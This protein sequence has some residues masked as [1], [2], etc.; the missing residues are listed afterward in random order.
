MKRCSLAFFIQPNIRIESVPLSLSLSFLD[1]RTRSCSSR[2]CRERVSLSACSSE[3]AEK[4]ETG[5]AQRRTRKANLSASEQ[6][7]VFVG[8][9]KEEKKEKPKTMTPLQQQQQAAADALSA[10]TKKREDCISGAILAGS[11]S[12]A[13]ALA[14]SGAAVAAATLFL[15]PFAAATNVSARTALI[16]TPAFG[17]FFL[18]SELALS[19]CARRRRR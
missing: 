9:Q 1:A 12:A 16:V 4:R 14:L 2:L 8:E 17:M 18:Q 6:T 10:A 15:R 19:D 7:L 3:K 13:L 11:K 5:S